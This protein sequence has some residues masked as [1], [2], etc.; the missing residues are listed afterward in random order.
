[1]EANTSR[2]ISLNGSNYHVWKGKMEDL[3][4]VN[5]FTCLRLYARKTGNNKLFLIKKL[6]QLKYND[7]TPITDHLNA[8]QGIIN[9][10]S[11]MGIKFEDEMQDEKKVVGFLFTIRRLGHRKQGRSQSRGPSN[12]GKHRSK[13]KGKFGDFEC[14]HCGRKGHTTRFCK[15]LKRKNKKANYNNQKNN[16]KKDDGGNDGAKVNTT[17]VEF[18]ICWDDE[19]VN[20]AHDDSSWV[21]DTGV[22][23]HVTSQR[24][25]YS[26]YTSGNFGN[27]KMGNHGLSKIVGIGDVCLKFDTGM[28]LVLRNVKHVPVSAGLLDDDGYNNNFGDGIWKLTHGSL[29]VARENM[30]FDIKRVLPRHQQL[31]GLA[32]RKADEQN[33]G[34]VCQ[35]S[36]DAR[37]LHIPKDERSKLDVKTKHR[38]FLGYGQ[39]EFGYR[40]YDP[41]QK[42]LVQSRHVVFEEDQT[43]K[44]VEKENTSAQHNDDLVDLDPVPPKHV[45][46]HDEDGVQN[47]VQDG[48]DDNDVDVP[49]QTEIDAEVHLELLSPSA[50]EN[51]HK[52]EWVESMQ[53]VMTSLHEKNIPEMVKLPKGKRALKNKCVYKVKIKEHTSRPRYKARSVVKEF[54]QRK[55]IDFEKIFS[56]VMKMGS[57]QVI[58]GLADILDLEVEQMDV[59]MVFLHGDLDKEIYIEQP[60][61][62]QVKGKEDYLCRLQ[63]SLYGLKQAPRLWYKK[64]ESVMGKQGYRKT[65]SDHCVFFQR[66][67]IDK[68]KVVSSSLTTNFKLTDKDY[69]SS[70]EEIE[71]MDRISYASAVGSLMYAMVCT[72]PDIAYVLGVVSRFLSNPGKKHWEAVKWILKNLRGNKDNMNST[73][74]YLMTFARGAVSWQSRLQKCVALSTIEAE[75]MAATEA[76]KELLWLKRFMQELDFRQQRYVVLCDN[77]SAI[78]LAKAIRYGDHHAAGTRPVPPGTPPRVSGTV[79]GTVGECLPT[80]RMRNASTEI[81]SSDSDMSEDPDFNESLAL[82]TRS[83]KKFAKKGNF[84]KKKPLTITDKPKTEPVDKATAICYN[85]QGKGHFAN[86]CRYR[87]SQFPPSSAKSSSKNP[88]YQRLKEKYKKMKFQHKGKGLIAE[89]CDWDDVSS[90]DSSDEEDTQVAL[91]AMIEEPTLAL[92]AKIEEVPEEVPTQAPEASFSTSPEASTSATESASQVPTPVVPLESLTQLDLVTLDLYKALNGKTSAEKMNIDLRDQLREC[93][94]KIKQLTILEE[95]Y[96]DQVTVNQTLCIEREKALAAK[97]RALAELNAEKVTIKGWSDAS[98]KVDEI[99]A[100]GRNVKN[101]KGL[102]FTSGCTRP[103]RSMLKFGMFVSSIPDPNAPENIP[104][105]SNTHTEGAHKSKKKTAKEKSKTITPS[106][107]K[108]PK[109]KNKVLGGGHSVS[110][111]KSFSQSPAPRLKIDL[112]QKTKEKKPIPPLSNAKGI[113]GTGPAHLKFKDFLDPTKRFLYRKCYHC[114]FNDHIA[115]KCPDATKTEKSAK[116]KKTPKTDNS[117]KGKK[118]VKTVPSV[119]TP[120]SKTDNSVKAV[121]NSTSPTD[122]SG[123]IDKGIWYLDSGCSRHMTGSKSVQSNYR[124]EKGPAVT[125]GG[126]GKGQT[127]G[128][129]TLTNGVTTFKRVAYVEGLMHN[130]LSISQLCDKNHKVSFSKKKCKVKNRRKE[131]ILTGVRHADIYIICWGS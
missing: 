107:T 53:D 92:M 41:I 109:P 8:F 94:E 116:V 88:K 30:A 56:L 89:D 35:M 99:L 79:P 128:Y 73:S 66:F 86:D 9:Q 81:E 111:T 54:S 123:S 28:E 83:F 130:L 97:E 82:L 126:N 77:Q 68:A 39:D 90:D 16:Q 19:M 57:I 96:K 51:E 63:K 87:K 76:C 7:G 50:M 129:G 103:D 34:R 32:E 119:K 24:D 93:Q 113:L 58:L 22:T 44:D 15:Q 31:N 115:S 72:R 49:K 62:F 80:S 91:M 98:E 69:P 12:K 85:C 37:L 105:S 6:I 40:L 20:L 101:R 59:K 104:S 70:K 27:V 47:D 42:K 36:L 11:G 14:Y 122:N 106:K 52:K 95:S 25:F 108:N 64:F 61:G 118:V 67:N 60:E 110:G 112:K 48:T 2:M 114:G 45:E 43:L 13:S 117:V 18:F 102:G 120:A 38:V 10:L 46:T 125:S 84:H 121:T 33:I 124:E 65:T 3:L 4:Y 26:S 17:T 75:Y 1:M 71:E 100:S 29:I 74:G 78:H 23:S 127:R 131:V 55:G 21:V 5:D